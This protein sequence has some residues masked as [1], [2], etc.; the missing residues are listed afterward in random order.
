MGFQIKRK[1]GIPIY[2]QLKEQ[3]MDEIRSG[4]LV[5]GEQ[6]PTERQLAEG[7]SISRNTVSMAYK[8]LE[9]EGVLVSYQGRGTFVATSDQVF[10]REGRK[11]RVLKVIDLA[12]EESAELGFSIDDFTDIVAERV[13]EKKAIF[14]QVKV[15]VIECDRE[16]LDFY[17]EQLHYGLGITV[18][19]IILAEFISDSAK[20]EKILAEVDLVV[21]TVYHVEEVFDLLSDRKKLVAVALEPEVSVIVRI[22]RSFPAKRTLLV[23]LTDKFAQSIRL[24]LGQS[25]INAADLKHTITSDREELLHLL[26]GMEMVLVSPGRKREVE[27]LVGPATEV[28][29]FILRPDQGSIGRLNSAILE[30]N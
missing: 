6:L 26:Q 27:D 5:G 23:C 24:Y 15:A 14:R 9:T 10:R 25:G 17:S 28:I 3:I 2:M 13:Q 18:V 7:L 16:Q 22:A 19:P 12:I 11:E 8:E 1:N 4:R 21:T 20:V 30:L 29:E